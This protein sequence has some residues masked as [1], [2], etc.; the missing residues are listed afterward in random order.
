MLTLFKARKIVSQALQRASEL[1]VSVSVAVCDANGRLIALNQMDESTGW[2]VDRCSMGKAVAAALTGQ[3]SDRLFEHFRA[4]GPRLSSSKNVVPARGQRGGLP[5]VE[6]GIVQG[7]CGVSGA[8]TLEQDEECAAA[9]IAALAIPVKER[10]RATYA[11]RS[12]S[13]LPMAELSLK[14]SPVAIGRGTP[15]PS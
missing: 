4:G 6:S 5:I 15:V 10:A 11:D 7:G 13:S 3:P 9:G 8:P 2:E 12:S 14:A 1:N